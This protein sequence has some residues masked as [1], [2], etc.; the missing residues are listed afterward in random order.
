MGVDLSHLAPETWKI[1]Y[2]ALANKKKSF[3][4]SNNS[5]Y[6]NNSSHRNNPN[7]NFNK[8]NF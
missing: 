2:Q 7:H 1:C 8:K 6:K 3:P 5:F 4:K